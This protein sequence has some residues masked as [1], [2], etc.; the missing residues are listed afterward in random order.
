[1]GIYALYMRYPIQRLISL[2]E[3]TSAQLEKDAA[4]RDVSVL[5]LVRCALDLYLS[6]AHDESAEDLGA[7]ANGQGRKKGGK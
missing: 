3:K 7:N 2:T 5:H 6:S 1:M 4:R